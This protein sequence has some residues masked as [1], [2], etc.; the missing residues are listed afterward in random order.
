MSIKASQETVTKGNLR[1]QKLTELLTKYLI[2][3]KKNLLTTHCEGLLKEK[4][5]FIVLCD[6]TPLQVR[7]LPNYLHSEFIIA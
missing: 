2:Q 4:N 6:L 3:R 5:D 1:A 7:L